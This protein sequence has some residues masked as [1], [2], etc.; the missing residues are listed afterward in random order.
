MTT[1]ENY[2][3]SARKQFE[4]YKLLGEK[5]FEQLSEEELFW[6]YHPDS[7]STAIIVNHMA[8]NMLS[9][10]TDFLTSDGEKEWRDRDQEFEDSIQSKADMLHRWEEGWQCLFAALDS[11]N[12]GNFTTQVFIRNQTHSV[13]EAI[14]RQLCHYAY[15]VGQIVL[16]GKMLKASQWQS[17]SVPRGKSGEYNQQK[18]AKGKHGGHFSDEFK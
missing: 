5:T 6:K 1:E 12:E 11:L 2:L 8:G 16:I 17:L 10:W 13:T 3:E 4:Y 9:R 15:H 14:N 18:L 7:N